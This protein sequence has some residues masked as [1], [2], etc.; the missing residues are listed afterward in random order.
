MQREDNCQSTVAPPF[1]PL[2][3][4]ARAGGGEVTLMYKAG[5]PQAPWC[6]CVRVHCACVC[7]FIIEIKR[8]KLLFPRTETAVTSL[9]HGS[10]VYLNTLEWD[11]R[12]GPTL[13]GAAHALQ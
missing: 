5:Y 8:I 4:Q 13:A 2:L 1:V 11:E 6:V 12:L 9:L 3:W 10:R 7:V